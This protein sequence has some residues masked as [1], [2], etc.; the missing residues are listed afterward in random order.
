MH[1][2]H[3][4]LGAN[5]ARSVKTEPAFMAQ[6]QDMISQAMGALSEANSELS[7]A[8]ER[9]I[10][11]VPIGNPAASNAVERPDFLAAEIIARLGELLASIEYNRGQAALINRRL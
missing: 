6:V 11:A 5:E 3:T 1:G 10:G 8:R 9:L 7:Q 4:M 2:S